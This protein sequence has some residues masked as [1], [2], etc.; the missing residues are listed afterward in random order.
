[1]RCHNLEDLIGECLDSIVSQPFDDY[2]VVLVNNASTDGSDAVCREYAAQCKRIRYHALEQQTPS[3]QYGLKASV[4]RY[5]HVVDG[6]DM[7]AERAYSPEV[8]G[9]L[10]NTQP[11]IAFGRFVALAHDKNV[12]NFVDSTYLPEK[13]NH[14][15]IE[16]V[17]DYLQTCEP[18]HPP[19]W[20]FIFKRELYCEAMFTRFRAARKSINAAKRADQIF[21]LLLLLNASAVHYFDKPLYV[22]RVRQSSSSRMGGASLAANF[23]TPLYEQMIMA[24]EQ[25]SDAKRRYVNYCIDAWRYMYCV[26]LMSLDKEQLNEHIA[27]L[28]TYARNLPPGATIAVENAE[29]LRNRLFDKVKKVC[30]ALD[31][32]YL[33]PTGNIGA[34]MFDILAQCGVSVLGYFDNDEQKSG[35][36]LKGVPVR[37]PASITEDV[38]APIVIAAAYK[39]VRQNIKQQFVSLGVSEKNIIVMEL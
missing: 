27:D 14:A 5:V 37:L 15:N 31:T 25:P 33:V 30:G 19:A 1:M 3:L 26:S 29:A 9:V 21:S 11:D 16:A 24:E 35:M 32:V 4:G 20:R 22:Y 34:C 10:Q 18:L 38:P 17:L 7:L 36:L 39:T 2:E 13:I 8:I 28:Q 12:F 23:F 6:D